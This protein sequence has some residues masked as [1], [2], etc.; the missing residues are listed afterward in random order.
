MDRVPELAPRL[1]VDA[2]R[3]FVEQQQ[4][5]FVH[6]A[7]RE[8]EALLPAA[9]ERAGELI[10]PF[11]EADALQRFLDLLPARTQV[12]QARDEV[13]VLARS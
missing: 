8:R 4:L 3:R 6:H 1:R 2:G 13:E 7:G 10:A 9:G 11:G 5:R 12:V